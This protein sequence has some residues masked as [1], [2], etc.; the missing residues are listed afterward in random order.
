MNSS[1]ST[2][3]GLAAGFQNIL[4][5]ALDYLPSVVAAVVVGLAAGP[6]VTYA[7]GARH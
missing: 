5:Q 6:V 4:A 1:V 7:G 3:Q 2:L